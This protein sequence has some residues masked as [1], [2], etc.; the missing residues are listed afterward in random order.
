MLMHR[1]DTKVIQRDIGI[2]SEI[3]GLGGHRGFGQGSFETQSHMN[4][5]TLV[6]SILGLQNFRVVEF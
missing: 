3:K 5:Q 6:V 2:C 1:W 4:I